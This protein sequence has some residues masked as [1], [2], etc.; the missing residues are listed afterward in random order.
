MDF[1]EII[2]AKQ[3]DIYIALVTTIIGVILGVVVDVIRKGSNTDSESRKHITNNVSITNIVNVY[4]KQERDC[5][6]I[7]DQSVGV[8]VGA[9]LIVC[10]IFYLFFR[11]EILNSVLYTT[12]LVLSVWAGGVLHSL[13][14]GY[15]SGVRWFVYLCFLIS[16]CF[17][18]ALIV[19]KAFVPNYAPEYFLDSQEIINAYG[20]KGLWNVS[21]WTDREWFVFHLMGVIGIFWAKSRVILSTVHFATVGNDIVLYSNNVSSLGRK[22][23]GYA[24]YWKNFVVVA[25]VSFISYFLVSGDFFIWLQY[26]FPE[27]MKDIVD[28]VLHG[29]R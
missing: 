20:A 27:Q 1:F 24:S 8:I 15:F 3:I 4:N 9:A 7:D 28:T 26:T 13:V 16:F 6:Q 22:T 23:A 17:V 25:I 21:S 14:R 5:Q 19:N 2:Q 18:C 10:G 11:E 29:R 12:L